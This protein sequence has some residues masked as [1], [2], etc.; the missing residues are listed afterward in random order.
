MICARI[1]RP[2]MYIDLYH[3]IWFHTSLYTF[4]I[5]LSSEGFSE[6]ILH[7]ITLTRVT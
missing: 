6:P 2:Y 5:K 7:N 1:F 3:G 4:I